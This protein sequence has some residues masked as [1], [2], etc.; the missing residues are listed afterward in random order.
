MTHTISF[1]LSCFWHILF[2]SIYHVFDLT[3]YF[4]LF[5]LSL[6]SHNISLCLSCLWSHIIF[7]FVCLVFDLTYYFPLFILPSITNTI[8]LFYMFCNHVSPFLSFYYISWSF[9]SLLFPSFYFVLKNPFDYPFFFLELWTPKLVICVYLDS[10]HP[11]HF[12]LFI[13]SISLCF[14][15]PFDHPSVYQFLHH[16]TVT[17]V[18]HFLYHKQC[19]G[20]NF[21][22]KMAIVSQFVLILQNYFPCHCLKMDWIWSCMTIFNSLN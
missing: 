5:I 7:P 19:Y 20:H 22:P 14:S 1:C 2:P 15:V 8:F 6:I 21:K 3:S 13:H 17:S 4:P 9:I 11:F 16:G 12:P 18:Y 10:V